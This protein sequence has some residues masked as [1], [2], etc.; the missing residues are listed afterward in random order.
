MSIKLLPILSLGLLSCNNLEQIFEEDLLLYTFHPGGVFLNPDADVKAAT[1][2]AAK[3]LTDAT[4]L[5]HDDEDS[6]VVPI[7][8][9]Q[10]PI[11]VDD[12]MACARTVTSYYP[13]RGV[14]GI[15]VEIDL[16]ASPCKAPEDVI[17]HELLHVHRELEEPE[18]GNI[19]AASGVGHAT[20]TPG[21][22]N[23]DT[24]IFLCE[25]APCEKFVPEVP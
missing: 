25:K 20:I 24:L 8:S 6:L 7:R 19:H 21:G 18:P 11:I 2:R 15:R 10:G 16:K 5:S 22:L 17:L 14:V 9:I 13:K 12:K 23:E 1:E 4:G 3:R